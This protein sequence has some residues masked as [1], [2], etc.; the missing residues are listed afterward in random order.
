ME[1]GRRWRPH[2]C[3]LI[4]RRPVSTHCFSAMHTVQLAELQTAIKDFKLGCDEPPCGE[5]LTTNVIALESTSAEKPALSC[6]WYFYSS[7][8]PKSP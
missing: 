6:T 7:L 2:L 3:A 1:H 5:F 4:F 8:C